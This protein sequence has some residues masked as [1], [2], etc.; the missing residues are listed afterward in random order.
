M[1]IHSIYYSPDFV[2]CYTVFFKGRGSL[3]CRIC[4]GKAIQFRTALGIG[5]DPA[6]FCQSTEGIPGR[7][8]GKKINVETLPELVL[9]A[10][11]NYLRN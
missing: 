3:S 9:N 1:K 10:I 6:Y 4:N 8:C 11:N 7:H 5:E 2:D